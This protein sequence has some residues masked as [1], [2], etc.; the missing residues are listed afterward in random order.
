MFILPF[1]AAAGTETAAAASQAAASVATT[2]T[3]TTAAAPQV[4]DSTLF[5]VVFVALTGITVSFAMAGLM[6]VLYIGIQRLTPD[7]KPQ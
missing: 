2:A 3:A 1:I 7:S 5:V 6:K 4:T